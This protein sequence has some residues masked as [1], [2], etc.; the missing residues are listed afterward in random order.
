MEELAA[1][2]N[3]KSPLR[4]YILGTEFQKV[5]YFDPIKANLN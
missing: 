4:T 1:I 2:S 5:I 3:E